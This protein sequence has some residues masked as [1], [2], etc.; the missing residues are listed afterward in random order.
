[1]VIIHFLPQPPKNRFLT[2]VLRFGGRGPR[3]ESDCEGPEAP[4]WFPQ[5]KIPIF[6][7]L[8]FTAREKPPYCHALHGK[9][10]FAAD[11]EFSKPKLAKVM[12]ILAI[13]ATHEIWPSGPGPSPNYRTIEAIFGG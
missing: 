2:H 9:S 5:V 7:I 4:T 6:G 11:F 8:N 12:T 1:M 3:S 10:V 13:L